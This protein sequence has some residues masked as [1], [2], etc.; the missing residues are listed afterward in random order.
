MTEVCEGPVVE[1]ILSATEHQ[2]VDLITMAT[3]TYSRRT[4]WLIVSLV[5]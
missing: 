1:S 5:L 3:H 4:H 2:S